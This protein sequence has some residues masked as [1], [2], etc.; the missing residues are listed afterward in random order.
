M[1]RKSS[2][3]PI[4]FST[5]QEK[6]KNLIFSYLIRALSKFPCT[7]ISQNIYYMEGIML[8]LS[9][10]LLSC[11]ML[12]TL[13][14]EYIACKSMRQQ[15]LKPRLQISGKSKFCELAPRTS[16]CARGGAVWII[17]KSPSSQ[18]NIHVYYNLSYI[19]FGLEK[20]RRLSAPP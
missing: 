11:V 5:E 17:C 14:G 2:L 3:V 12:P 10:K 13:R 9:D 4:A 18:S 6:I 20:E 16:L 1:K 8:T 7:L 19:P 15:A